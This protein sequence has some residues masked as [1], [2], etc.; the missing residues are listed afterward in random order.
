MV[1]ALMHNKWWSKHKHWCRIN[2][3]VNIILLLDTTACIFT[4]LM[5][6]D[7]YTITW[8]M[9][10]W[11]LYL[12]GLQHF[13]LMTDHRPLVPILNH[14][15]LDAVENPHLQCLKKKISL[16]VHSCVA[17]WQAARHTLSHVP[18]S[19]FTPH[20]ETNCVEAGS[21]SSPRG[22]CLT[23]T[24]LFTI[25]MLQRGRT[26]CTTIFKS[27]CSQDFLPII[28][29]SIICCSHSW[30]YWTASQSTWTCTLWSKDCSSCRS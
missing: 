21:Y 15:T 4:L 17:C 11:K 22:R 23:P 3:K 26:C 27:A 16:S 20:D 25:F 18:I 28:T 19:Q 8:A 1:K 14:W 24:G 13:K 7:I 5:I 12:T 30:I 9:S 6:F 10:Q 29:T 2:E